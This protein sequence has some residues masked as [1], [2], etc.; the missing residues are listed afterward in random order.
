MEQQLKFI[1]I[2]A[3]EDRLQDGVPKSIR[4]LKEM[5]IH[6]WVLTGDK[7]ETAVDIARSCLLFTRSTYLAY[8]VEANSTKESEDKLL[9]AHW[10]LE[11]KVEGGLVLDGQTVHF[12][13]QSAECRKIIYDLGVISRSCICARL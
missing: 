2:T 13:M 8:A 11:G 10:E 12:A 1:G 5:G 7:V 6:L 9:K 3:V 4:T